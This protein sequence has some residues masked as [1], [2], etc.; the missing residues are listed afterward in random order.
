MTNACDIQAVV[1]IAATLATTLIRKV[2][3]WT[4]VSRIPASMRLGQDLPVGQKTFPK[5]KTTG[6]PVV[7]SYRRSVFPTSMDGN[8]SR[9]VGALVAWLAFITM[10]SGRN[11]WCNLRF[12]FFD[13]NVEF[14]ML[15]LFHVFNPLSSPILPQTK[16]FH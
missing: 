16:I 9:M 3:H 5:A 13:V 2:E 11:R 7:F 8:F 6:S 15:L 12:K 10:L 4:A 14:L 1:T